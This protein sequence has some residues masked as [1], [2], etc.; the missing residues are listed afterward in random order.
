[1]SA[2]SSAPASSF[3]FVVARGR[4]GTTLLRAMLD[5]HPELS[6]PG[7]SHFVPHFV[8]QRSRYERPDGF[9]TRRFGREL[10]GRWGWTIRR[11][12]L[13]DEEIL[14]EI[15]DPPPSEVTEVVRRLYAAHAR[16]EG[17]ARYGDKTP[18][19]ILHIDLLA[20]A[21]PEARFIHLIRDG[22]DVARSYLDADF[23][24]QTLGQAAITWDRYVRAGRAAGARLGPERYVE[25]RYE[26][27]VRDPERVL[28]ELMPFIGLE[29]DERMLRYH[30][31]AD[32]LV[33][34][35]SHSAHHRNLYKPPTPGLRDWRREFSPRQVAVFEALAGDLLGELGYERVSGERGFS[36][37]VTAGRHRA[38]TQIRRAGHGI[39]VRV[40]RQRRR[41]I[42]SINQ[43]RTAGDRGT[44]T[45]ASSSQTPQT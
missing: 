16:A 20:S 6:I 18:S 10:L 27:L 35:L 24:S 13:S 26:D 12:S 33:G 17:K 21:F 44:A 19:Y 31:Q 15:Q 30:E 7:E 43:R 42:R 8:V 23:G 32:Q 29:F 14:R 3:P 5:A 37:A 28:G 39:R 25:V 11:W 34:G 1:M 9:D 38:E 45:I 36:V 41:I 40:R 4:S 2:A 22:R